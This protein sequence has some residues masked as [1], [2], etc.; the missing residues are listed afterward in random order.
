MFVQTSNRLVLDYAPGQFTFRK[1]APSATDEAVHELAL[2][3][4][5]FQE[6]E[7]KR[8]RRVAEFTFH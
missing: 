8:I 3:L 1:F 2:Q 5:S 6:D 7:V 4:N